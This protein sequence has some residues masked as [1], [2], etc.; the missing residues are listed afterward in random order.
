MHMLAKANTLVASGSSAGWTTIFAV[1][2]LIAR[3][4][5]R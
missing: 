5:M 4:P 2:V 3:R 1:V